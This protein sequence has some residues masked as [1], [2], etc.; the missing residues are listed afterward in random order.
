MRAQPGG[1]LTRILRAFEIGE[2]TI[3]VIVAVLLMAL[4]L[5]L[6]IDTVRHI[7]IVVSGPYNLPVIVLTVLE[8][9]LLLFIV[10]ELL[11][12]VAIALRHRGALDPEPFL[13]VGLVAGIRRVLVVT[14]EAEQSFRWNPEGI[15][16]LILM[17]LILV[18]AITTYAW[19][20]Y[21]SPVG[22][23]ANGI[24]GRGGQR[25]GMTGPVHIVTRCRHAGA[26]AVREVAPYGAMQR[27]RAWTTV[28]V[29]PS[30]TVATD[31]PDRG[32]T[33]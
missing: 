1:L 6:I 31:V 23:E 21:V 2:D 16:L 3:H 27:N 13:V 12:T 5:V 9:A 26:G 28:E 24:G 14:G 22:P 33:E 32:R 30:R 18:M 17:L 10:A 11:H 19:L 25:T 29:T 8:E 4:G 15:E 7:V 20:R